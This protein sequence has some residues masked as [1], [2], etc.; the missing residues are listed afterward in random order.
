[1]TDADQIRALIDDN[2]AMRK[3][4]CQLAQ[5]ALQVCETY[6]GTHRL[7]LAVAEWAKVIANEGGRPHQHAA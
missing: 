2:A 5:A 6:D 7:A 1:M 3:A 4:G